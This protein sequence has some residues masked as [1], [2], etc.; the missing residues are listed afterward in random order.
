MGLFCRDE[1][2][3]PGLPCSQLCVELRLGRIH[4]HPLGEISI[5]DCDPNQFAEYYYDLC[6]ALELLDNP[7]HGLFKK[8]WKCPSH[9]GRFVD[10]HWYTR[11]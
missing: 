8:G 11:G 1:L 2:N 5:R 9:G 4:Y 7:K 6:S 3:K 10:R